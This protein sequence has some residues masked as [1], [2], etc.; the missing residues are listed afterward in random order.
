MGIKRILRKIKRKLVIEKIQAI[1]VP[2]VEGEYLKGDLAFI[3]GGAG[4]I[5][6]AIAERF[7][8]N[9][10]SVII[11]GTKKDKLENACRKLGENASYV[12]MDAKVVKSFDDV[13]SEIREEV[14]DRKINILVNCAGNHGP[15]NFWDITPDDWDNV[16]DVNVRAVYFL[17][18]LFASYF[19]DEG[20]KGHIL[21]VGSASALRPGK[22][23]YEISKAAVQSMTLGMAS[24]FI[25]YGIVVNSLCPGPTATS[26]LG[27]EENSSLTWP[28]NPTGRLATPKEIA[29]W[30]VFMV[31]SMGD[32]VVG[33]SFFVTG[34]AGTICIDK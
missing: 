6:F 16:M 24:E 26:M 23:P 20:I 25:K 11:S 29:N 18:R 34:G 28:A 31:S 22:T 27:K 32:Y 15:S 9:G 10:C 17:S 2:I 19:K 14:G 8:D 3:T 4:G 7:I 33:D 5:G 21:N 30:A 13:F 12:V 1:N